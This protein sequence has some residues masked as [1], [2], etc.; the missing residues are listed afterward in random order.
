MT[1]VTRAA[2]TVQRVGERDTEI[3]HS[4]RRH[5]IEHHTAEYIKS[6]LSEPAKPFITRSKVLWI[7]DLLDEIG[8]FHDS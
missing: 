2:Q 3:A 8:T 5:F 6:V 4:C 7:I 1:I